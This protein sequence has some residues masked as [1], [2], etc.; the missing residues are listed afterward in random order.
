M[1]RY[2]LFDVSPNWITSVNMK[3]AFNTGIFT[4]EQ[5]KE[6]RK[7]LRLRPEV[8]M[9][10]NILADDAAKA[11]D[12]L[13]ACLNSKDYVPIWPE[14]IDIIGINDIETCYQI[15]TEPLA[16]FFCL[17]N[18]VNHVMLI[19]RNNAQEPMLLEILDMGADWIN[20]PNDVAGWTYNANTL[21]Y[22]AREMILSSVQKSSITT[23]LET[24]NVEFKD[25]VDGL[26]LEYYEVTP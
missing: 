1:N 2:Q 12:L 18:L 11:M 24:V 22:P 10:Y 25:Y 14:Q 9:S 20:V 26:V 13:R 17:Q 23:E 7:P 5:Y 4:S 3:Y 21:F 15:L 19:D 16:N 8:S 6:Q